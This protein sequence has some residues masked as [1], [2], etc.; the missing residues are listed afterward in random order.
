[1]GPSGVRERRT[2]PHPTGPPRLRVRSGRERLGEA[3]T[4]SPGRR[5]CWR[6]MTAEHPHDSPSPGSRP[7]A[8]AA[9]LLRRPKLWLMPT[10]L[11]GLL[12]LLLS[13]LYMGGIINPERQL[14]R[15]PI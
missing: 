13:L 12:A 6:I 15:M 3:N 4:P 1:V 14:H 9:T 8:R 10:I 7:W 5:R 11:T 2:R